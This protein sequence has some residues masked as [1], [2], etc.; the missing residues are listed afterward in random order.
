MFEKGDVVRLKSGEN[1]MTISRRIPKISENIFEVVYFNSEGILSVHEL[2]EEC[3]EKVGNSICQ[4][5]VGGW[6]Q[7]LTVH[8]GK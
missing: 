1:Q 5:P 6:V 3:L 8:E 4:A 2:Y 7:Q